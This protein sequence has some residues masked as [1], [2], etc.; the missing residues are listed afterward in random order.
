M[1]HAQPLILN[2]KVQDYIS[3]SLLSSVEKVLNR[4][5]NVLICDNKIKFE[6][7]ARCRRE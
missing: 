6:S 3:F 2:V 4:I 7:A 1:T 5:S